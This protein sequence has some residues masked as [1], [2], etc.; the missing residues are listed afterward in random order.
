MA[1]TRKRREGA[2]VWHGTFDRAWNCWLLP[3]LGGSGQVQVQAGGTGLTEGRWL[4]PVTRGCPRAA[5]L[6]HTLL[7]I[8]VKDS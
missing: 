7:W 8:I 6:R 2:G 1:L 3:A 4:E 5:A